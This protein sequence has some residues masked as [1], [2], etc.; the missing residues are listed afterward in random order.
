MARFDL[1][2]QEVREV[3]STKP[4]PVITV[5]KALKTAAELNTTVE[6]RLRVNRAPLRTKTT[7]E[8]GDER[9]TRTFMLRKSEK[10][11]ES[12]LLGSL[13]QAYRRVNVSLR[14]E[15]LAGLPSPGIILH[16][17]AASRRANRPVSATWRKGDIMPSAAAAAPRTAPSVERTRGTKRKYSGSQ[18]SEGASKK[19]KIDTPAARQPQGKEKATTQMVAK[20]VDWAEEL[21]KDQAKQTERARLAKVAEEAAIKTTRRHTKR[22]A[23]VETDGCPATKKAKLTG[24][25]AGTEQAAVQTPQQSKKREATEIS[26]GQE[27]TAADVRAERLEATEAP[28]EAERPRDA[29]KTTE[30][31]T[32]VGTGTPV[33]LMNG[34]NAC[35]SNAVVQMLSAALEGKDLESLLGS[36]DGLVT[37]E[38]E[39]AEVVKCLSGRNTASRALS[40]AMGPLEGAVYKA[41][42][43]ARG[44]GTSKAI[45]RQHLHQL[46]KQL[47]DRET[48]GA[49][50][51]I[52]FQ[53]ALSI[54]VAVMDG[55]SGTDDEQRE[56]RGFW[57]GGEQQD[58][59]EYYLKL[60]SVLCDESTTADDHA[61][62][63]LFE[64]STETTDVC[65]NQCVLSATSRV[66]ISTYHNITM[67][68]GDEGKD[69]PRDLQRR[70]KESMTSHLADGKCRKCKT[71]SIHKRTAITSAPDNLVVKVCRTDVQGSQ[72][73]FKTSKNTDRLRL[74]LSGKVR[75]DGHQYRLAA[76]V[77]H[78]GGETHGGHYTVFRRSAGVWSHLNDGHV[79]QVKLVLPSRVLAEM[80]ELPLQLRR[81][82]YVGPKSYGD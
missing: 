2:E 39:V 21:H 10:R 59:F 31:Q 58:S 19:P 29:V 42:Q 38:R 18:D 64:I 74:P 25:V 71:G 61:M 35:F 79:Q 50:V 77:M 4:T 66:D 26:H 1:T 78:R 20:R 37:F 62:E 16:E 53:L 9:K 52:A 57:N 24:S 40:K 70:I 60:I 63:A 55:E 23:G 17:A 41:A 36:L 45:I 27:E 67:P 3:T 12:F 34:R 69:A 44:D 11:Y 28:N 47:Q 68:S 65:S 72:E 43:S 15:F 80:I 56:R 51:P 76:V 54:G 7:R 49:V 5:A 81:Y 82:R 48:F 73:S 22:P 13:K 33:G 46:L 6:H 30:M 14:D 75:L 8:Q 32:A